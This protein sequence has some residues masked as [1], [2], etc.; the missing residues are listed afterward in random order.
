MSQRE[1]D[2]VFSPEDFLRI[3]GF[4]NPPT[5]IDRHTCTRIVPMKILCL[6]QSRTG[7]EALRAALFELGYSDI[8]HMMSVFRQNL[9]DGEMWI[10]AFEAKF[11]GKGREFGREEWDALLG[12]F[13]VSTIAILGS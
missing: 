4:Q 2:A 1:L 9:R 5:N 10:E 11:Q 6:G 13:M 8:Y 3:R 12:H 7:T